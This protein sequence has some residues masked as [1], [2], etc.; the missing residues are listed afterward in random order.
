MTPKLSLS[1]TVLQRPVRCVEVNLYAR[2]ALFWGFTRRRMVVLPT[3]RE[4]LSASSVPLEDGTDR[5]SRSVANKP[6][7][8]AA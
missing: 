3:F 4:R 8:Y 6:P 2:S 7:F 1:G 5:L